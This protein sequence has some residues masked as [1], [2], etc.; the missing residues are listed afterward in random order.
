MKNFPKTIKLTLIFLLINALVWLVFGLIILLGLH[1]ALPEDVLYK[2]GMA[3]TSLVA[4]GVLVGLFFLM[5]NRVRWG[6][7]AAVAALALS[8]VVTIF[9]DVG[10]ID[11]AV[12]LVMLIPLVL[13]MIDRKWYLEKPIHKEIND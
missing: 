13:L 4:A 3:T 6:W 8:L 9:D 5:K 1:P 7:Y 2:W 11:L 10:L 12:M